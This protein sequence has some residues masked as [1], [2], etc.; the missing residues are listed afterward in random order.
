MFA[1]VPLW[2]AAQSMHYEKIDYLGRNGSIAGINDRGAIVGSFAAFDASEKAQP[3]GGLCLLVTNAQDCA[4][5][6][7]HAFIYT[8]QKFTLVKVPNGTGLELVAI[9]NHDQ[10]LL[11]GGGDKWFVYDIAKE[12]FRPI[13]IT[14]RLASD[15]GGKPFHIRNLKSLNDKGEVLAMIGGNFVFGTPALGAP[16]SLTP[17][18]ELGEFTLIPNCPGGGTEATGLNAQDQVSGTCHLHQNNADHASTTGFIYHDGAF[19]SFSR[20]LARTTYAAALNNSGAV[21]GYYQLQQSNQVLAFVYDGS[22]FTD[23][24][25]IVRPDG[26]VPD[27]TQP[28]GITSRGQVVGT[29]VDIGRNSDGFLATP[30]S[31]ADTAGSAK[32]PPSSN[33]LS[34]N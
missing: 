21:A 4:S 33:P 7:A 2:A 10:I 31:G 28:S 6:G 11:T 32:T 23:V 26:H 24:P 1:C 15:A 14:G 13:G 18:T 3:A 25:V 19:Q 34:K 27:S 12:T 17:P 9:N 22:K 20:P 8:Q 5:S 30:R 16:G 29:I